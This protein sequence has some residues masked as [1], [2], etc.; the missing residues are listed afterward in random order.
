MK[1]FEEVLK[2][3]GAKS[4]KLLRES[5]HWNLWEA[6]YATPV[7]TIKGHY[8]YLKASCPLSEASSSNLSD[9]GA[10]SSADGYQV[11]VTPRSDLAKDL[12]ATKSRFKA[13]AASTTSQLLQ[14]NLLSGIQY[15]PLQREEHFISPSINRGDGQQEID[16][17]NFLSRWL[18]G[19]AAKGDSPPIALLTA[20]GGNGKT[21]LARELCETVRAKYPR[22]LPLLIESD[23]WK[24]IANTGFT[25]DTLWDIAIARRLENCNS[26]RSNQSALRV[27]M[28]EGL[29]VIIFDGF[30]ELASASGDSNRP[31]EI[32]QELQNLFTPEDEDVRA[33]VILTSR[34]T[35]WKS[36]EP[37]ISEI[38]PIEVFQLNGFNNEQRKAYFDTRLERP[39]DRDVAMRLARQV[40][41]PLIPDKNHDLEVE[42]QNKDRLSGTP[43]VLALIA[44]YVEDN[45]SD[46]I[47]PYDADP[48]EPLLLGVCRRENKRQV[49]GISPETQ[50]SIFEE[51]FRMGGNSI[52]QK[53]LDFILQVYDILDPGV[54]HRF[55]NHFFLQRNTTDTLAAR[56][57]VLK[58]YFVARFLARGLQKLYS[59]TPEREI[60]STLSQHF[61]GQ[62]QVIEWLVWQLK[63]LPS[64]RRLLAIMHAY[65]II[66]S[67][68]NIA[69]KHRAGIAISR[70]VSHLIQGDSKV[71]RSEDFCKL[72]NAQIKGST[73][74]IRKVTISGR[75]RSIDFSNVSIE[76]CSPVDVEFHGCKFDTTTVFESCSFEGT[77]DF[78]NC[79]GVA[80]VVSKDNT[81]S[82]DAEI[83]LSRFFSTS[84]STK[85]KLDFAEEALTRALKKFKGDFGFHGIQYR[86]R[87]GSANPRNPYTVRIWDVLKQAGVTD[88]HTI[89]G[90]SEGGLHICDE[91]ELRKEIA[92]Y[93]DNGIVGATLKKVLT[94]L[95]DE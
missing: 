21:T 70:V 36:I 59:A 89:A 91:K 27:L 43:F 2:S 44:H 19:E 31:Q 10:L 79:E 54:R 7:K 32:I 38:G 26:L 53:D 81:L 13:K 68:E 35:Y 65:D 82:P 84:P 58:V 76:G 1:H 16:G 5:R 57:E 28:Q 14:E 49:L 60:A 73:K 12:S 50:L 3:L 42:S 17:L 23:Q 74:V 22:V 69:N 61:L 55:T 75:M 37:A 48:L 30:D 47:N 90:V 6:E 11:I 86:R 40:S 56:F 18:V 62:S 71:E 51:V 80:D 41:G 39:A 88:N 77:L 87:N 64:E 46:D 9:F 66:S 25:L 24:S 33:K 67:P 4:S 63:E 85:V 52:N 45:G 95:V 34:T 94:A 78:T 20:D 92:Q 8:L 29:L 83:T 15:R 93:L 72:T